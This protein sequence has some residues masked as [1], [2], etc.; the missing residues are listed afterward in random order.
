M[1]Q[2]ASIFGQY[3]TR[4]QVMIDNSADRFA[5][6]WYP[7]YFGWAPPQ[8][9]LNYTSVIGKSRIEAAASV[10]NR[11]SSTPLRSRAALEKLNGEIPAIKEMFKMDE[12][13]Y[14][15]FLMLQ[16]LN[17]DDNSKLTQLM[18]F[19]FA[20]VKHVGD[21]AHKRVDAMVLEAV[22]T[23]KI[24]IDT[25]NNPDGLAYGTKLDLLMPDDNKKTAALSWDSSATA[26]PLTDIENVVSAAGDKGVS[27]AKILMSNTLFGKFKKCKEVKDTLTAYYYGPIA[28]GSNTFA[29][30]SLDRINEYLS[31]NGLPTVELVDVPIGVE[32]DGVI[33]TI[34]PFSDSNVSFIPAGNLGEIKNAVA[35]ESLK[36]VPQLSYATYNRALISKWYS[37]EPFGEWT[38][39]ELNAFPAFGAI[40]STFILSAVYA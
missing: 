5:P 33:S 18:D 30:T 4:M 24:T 7:K 15:D 9:T 40:D 29:I 21:A 17:V 31:A 32:K 22:S 34:R 25:T 2:L 1:S 16:Q 11:D 37:N 3:A 28:T 23:G 27:F 38:K 10:V 26:T 13:D 39:V 20:D 35:I 8:S 19:L 14:R 36:P 12:N 6:L